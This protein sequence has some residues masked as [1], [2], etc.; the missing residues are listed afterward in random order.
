MIPSASL[1]T[2]L[3]QHPDDVEALCLDI[4]GVLL[5]GGRRLPG[6]RHLL[7]LLRK[8]AIAF[9]LLTND[10]NHSPAEKIGS[11]KQ[12][13]LAI[14]PAQIVS[15]GHA[16]KAIVQSMGLA[17]RRFFAMG[18]TGRPCYAKAAGLAVTRDLNV[19]QDCEGV[20]I[21]EEHYDWEPVINSVVNYFIEH[22]HAP[23]IV[24][25]PDEFYPAPKLKIHIAAGGVAR[26]IQQVL[27]AYG[28]DISPIYLG[29]PHPPIFRLACAELER[30]L[31]YP[32]SPHKVL[33]VGDN[34]AADVAGGRNMGYRTALLLT[35]VT[36]SSALKRSKL[37][38]DMVFNAI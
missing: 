16:I 20:I 23:L 33:M 37:I 27:K 12:A 17:G 19:L 22:P 2:W 30:Q 3:D 15:C 9:V 1:H 14:T 29:K 34:L 5:T 24:P 11:L 32:I 13:G 6:S 25:N 31:G 38:P 4:D 28:V 10:C 21:G 8:K 18:D 35:G 26:F 7:D 36:A